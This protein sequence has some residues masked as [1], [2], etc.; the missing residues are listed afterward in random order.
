MLNTLQTLG[1]RFRKLLN[2]TPRVNP[3][4]LAD[5]DPTIRW[6]AVR[7]IARGQPQTE[8]IPLVSQL[9]ADPDPT[10]RYEAVLVLSIW[11]AKPKELQP[12]VDLLA[13]DPVPES[14]IAILDLL[15]HLPLPA[16]HPLIQDRLEH[17]NPQVR[18]AAACALG[19]Y[20][21]VEDIERLAPLTDDPVPEVRRAACQALSEINDP[22]VPYVLR[23]HLQDPD[24][25][26][27]QIVR[28][29]IDNRQK[30][31]NAAQH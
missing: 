22:T 26:T 21:M 10:I 19:T 2:P 30:R 7:T 29:A 18:A 5:L 6:R 24:P 13:S 1:V 14:T 9:L 8:L 25:I 4:D 12:T 28:Q 31:D 3:D 11:E 27:R 15:K 17:D 20:Q 16:S 23:Q